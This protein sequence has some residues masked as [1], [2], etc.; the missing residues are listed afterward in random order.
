MRALF[1]VLL[2]VSF[3]LQ[4]VSGISSPREAIIQTIIRKSNPRTLV[5]PQ[6]YTPPQYNKP[7]SD[8]KNSSSGKADIPPQPKEEDIGFSI[9]TNMDV[10]AVSTPFMATAK[11]QNNSKTKISSL[12]Y[13]D[14]LESGIE[15]LPNKKDIVT[16][17]TKKR[18]ISYI[19]DT[20]DPG[21]IISF[22]YQLEIVNVTAGNLFIH[23]AI[24]KNGG[25]DLQASTTITTGAN[26]LTDH[27]H[28]DIV[29][30]GGGWNMLGDVSVYTASGELPQNAVLSSTKIIDVKNGPPIQYKL[31]VFNTGKVSLNASG[32]IIK[33]ETTLKDRRPTA[34]TESAYIKFRFDELTDLNSIPAGK[35][36]YVAV[37]D[38]TNSVWVKVPILSEDHNTNT[39][40]VEAKHFST[41]GAGL[42]TSMPQNGAGALLFDQPYSSLFTGSS[43]YQI[44]ISIP[45]GRAGLTPDISLSY[46][47]GT[48]DGVLGDVQAPWVGEGW[49][50]DDA[51]IV[52]KLTTDQNGYGY[53]NNFVL[54]LNGKMYDLIRDESNRSRYYVKQDGFL[55]IKL[56]N[57]ALNNQ[58]EVPNTTGDGM[59]TR[60]V[61]W[62]FGWQERYP[63]AG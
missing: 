49:N 12:H 31:D 3:M 10:V 14:V 53:S 37:Y 46:S 27:S 54:T 24:L 25:S 36:P 43:E 60:R 19:I 17:D 44:P 58:G 57:Y 32:K 15:Y 18:E 2:I 61:L 56:H 4:G 48:V 45:S 59:G 38:D 21:Q 6:Y 22:S 39:V 34:F 1:N 40:T 11:I 42:G 55:Y 26:G 28:I 33:Q 13:S 50:I 51:E 7:T 5:T 63:G 47:S 16:Y 35:E 52:R 41:W 20:I 8:N 62:P 30:P 29:Q 23:T 9:S